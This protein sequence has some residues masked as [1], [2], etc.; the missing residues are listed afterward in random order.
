VPCTDSLREISVTKEFVGKIN[1][2]NFI[3]FEKLNKKKY[4]YICIIIYVHSNLYI[5]I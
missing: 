4:I 3:L 1:Y 5:Y 2:L